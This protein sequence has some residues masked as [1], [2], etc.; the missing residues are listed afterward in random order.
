MA[1]RKLII[2]ALESEMAE[3]MNKVK[4]GISVIP[5]NEKVMTEAMTR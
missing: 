1:A 2:Y 5:E 4:C 3:K